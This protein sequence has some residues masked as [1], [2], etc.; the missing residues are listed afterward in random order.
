MKSKKPQK[1]KIVK[2]APVNFSGV[3]FEDALRAL[4]QTPQPKR[5]AY[6]F[7]KQP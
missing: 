3:K 1:K 6:P 5:K 2:Q 4:I 7:P